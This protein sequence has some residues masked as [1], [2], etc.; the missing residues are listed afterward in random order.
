[1]ANTVDKAVLKQVQIALEN[2]DADLQDIN[3]KVRV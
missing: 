3:K 2:A 1:M